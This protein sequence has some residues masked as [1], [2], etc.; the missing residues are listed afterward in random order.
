MLNKSLKFVCCIFL[1]TAMAYAAQSNLRYFSGLTNENPQRR[2]LEF[3]KAERERDDKVQE[4]ISI[5][6]SANL[7]NRSMAT[8]EDGPIALAIA[9]LGKYRAPEAVPVFASRLTFL[10]T[11]TS[12]IVQTEIRPTQ[13]FYPCVSALLRIGDHNVVQTMLIR[14]SMSDQDEERALAAWVMME[15]EGK[16]RAINSIESMAAGTGGENRQRLLATKE[17]LRT[18]KPTYGPPAA[19]IANADLN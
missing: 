15:I 8:R 17:N 5:I 18:F 11:R 13:Y 2:V 19:Y 7:Q 9:L 12:P 10:P 16:E 1:V 3:S 4:L 6:E 14:I